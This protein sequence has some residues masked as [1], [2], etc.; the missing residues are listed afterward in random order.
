MPTEGLVPLQHKDILSYEEIVRILLIAVHIGVRKVRITGGEPLIRKNVSHLIKLIKSVKGIQDLSLTTNG[1]LL[2]KYA[3]ELADAGL[4]R[5]NISLDSLKALRYREIT[6]GGDLDPVLKGIESAEKAGLIPVKINMVPMRGFN[7]DEIG[8]FAKLTLKAPY[9]VRF[10][11]FMPFGKENM[12]KPEYFI[13]AE[14][15]KSIAERIGALHP[16]RI[17]RSGPARYFKFDG[18]AGIL[19]FISPL[20]NHFCEKCNRLRLTA[21]GK[22]RPCLFSETEIDIKTA[23]RSDAPDHEIERLVRLAIQVKPQGHAMSIQDTALGKLLHG[24]GDY[25]RPMSKIGG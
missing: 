1:I 24:R 14:E 11:E 4:E 6:R 10:I 3:Q 9:Q 7:D 18:A 13:S 22:L 5:V 15:I 21:D 16:V 2:E 8:A 19:G 12:W 23:L 25:S 20:S 17:R